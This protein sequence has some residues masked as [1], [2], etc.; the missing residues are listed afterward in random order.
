MFHLILSG[1]RAGIFGVMHAKIPR[2][3]SQCGGIGGAQRAE[4]RPKRL[5]IALK[6][7]RRIARWIH[8]DKSHLYVLRIGSEPQHVQVVFVTVDPARDTSEALERYVK[9]FG[10]NVSALRAADPA[11]LRK[12]TRDFRVHY[13]KNPGAQSGEYEM[14]HTAASYV[15]DPRGRLRLY[16]LYRQ[17]PESW[18]HDLR[19]LLKEKIST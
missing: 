2:H 8:R 11:A 14:E 16:V 9:A 3:F 6:R 17:R 19:L 1:L 4:V 18:L 15:F 10:P 5:D 12:V 13:A 7:L